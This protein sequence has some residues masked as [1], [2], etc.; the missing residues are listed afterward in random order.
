M[1]NLSFALE[2]NVQ[3][4]EIVLPFKGQVSSNV[5]LP[6]NLKLNSSKRGLVDGDDD[7]LTEW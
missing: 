5:M 4:S 1:G 3:L 6:S 2:L 7:A